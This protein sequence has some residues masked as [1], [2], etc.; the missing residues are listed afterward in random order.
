MIAGLDLDARIGTQ[1]ELQDSYYAA[2]RDVV[3]S[4]G[5]VAVPSVAAKTTSTR[6]GGQRG[7]M[8]GSSGV[9]RSVARSAGLSNLLVRWPASE[10]R[11]ASLQPNP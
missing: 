11:T 5:R 4:R 7:S 3:P 9:I 6:S 8:A 2:R 10:E 1:A